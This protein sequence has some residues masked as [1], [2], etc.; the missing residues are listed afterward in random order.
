TI[1]LSVVFGEESYREGID[2]TTEQFYQKLKEIKDLPSTSQPP[3]GS[4]V[5]LF[6]QLSESYDAVISIHLSKRFSGTHD[7]AVSAGKMVDNIEVFAFDTA[8]SAMPQGLFAIAA[9][10]LATD[11]KTAEEII[12][13]LEE[14]KEKTYA[15]FMVEDL[16][17]LERG[18]RL[19]KGQALIGSLLNIKPVLHI[20]D[21]LIIPFEK[22]RTRKKALNRIMSML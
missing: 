13:C 9:S 20:V 4:F 11:G 15:Y 12:T 18:G 16:S 19:N 6:E 1:P 21:G 17:H 3:I 22:I 14:M 2:I 8:L 7:V 5:Q 10:E